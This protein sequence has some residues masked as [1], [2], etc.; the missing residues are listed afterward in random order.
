MA[1]VF[2]GMK[3]QLVPLAKT[4]EAFEAILDGKMDSYPENVSSAVLWSL[5]TL[6]RRST[7]WATSTPSLRR[8]TRWPRSPLKR[9][10]AYSSQ[11]RKMQV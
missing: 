3:G 6:T 7:W 1:E 8:P 2:T 4:V 11:K 10:A 5:L 9:P